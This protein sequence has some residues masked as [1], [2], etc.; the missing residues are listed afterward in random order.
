MREGYFE[1][2]GK[3]PVNPSGGMR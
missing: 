3:V 2:G 1:L